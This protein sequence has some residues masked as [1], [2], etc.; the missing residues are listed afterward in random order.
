MAA[1]LSKF[2][3]I[4]GDFKKD[5]VKETKGVWM[6]YKRCQYLVARAHRNNVE[7]LKTMETNM[8]PYQWAIDRN[9]FAAIKD[10]AEAAIQV[11]YAQTVL[12]GIK[13]LDGTVLDYTPEDGVALFQQLPDLWD[14]IFK[15]AGNETNYAP[16]AVE[17]D[18]KN[19]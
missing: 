1:D 19:S 12:L 3:D 4:I 13:K 9:N 17:A 14:E 5:S 8:R 6:T 2:A 15:F 10:V 18:S 16:D 7:F 11:V